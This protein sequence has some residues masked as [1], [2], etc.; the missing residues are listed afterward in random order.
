MTLMKRMADKMTTLN[1]LQKK[2]SSAKRLM[3]IFNDLEG[4]PE[5]PFA[6][7]LKSFEKIQQEAQS[8]QELTQFLLEDVLM[9]SL[10]ATFYEEIL[11][12]ISK[13]QDVAIPLINRFSEDQNLRE[14]TVAEQAEAH[15]NYIIS[16]GTCPGCTHCDNHKDVMELVEY[17][18]KQDFKFFVTLFLGM[19]TI[20]YTMEALLYDVIPTSQD[21]AQWVG[22]EHV[23][24]L[25]Q[26]IYQFVEQKL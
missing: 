23:L 7:A 13:N 14:Q 2:G 11:D 15:L 3:Q 24:A 16:A 21:Y 18:K 22:R 19:Q 12:T 6:L 17:W 10:Y 25:R 20:Q 9:S 4:S 26:E 8:Q 1:P 5:F